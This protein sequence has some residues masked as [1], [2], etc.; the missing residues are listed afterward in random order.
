[1]LCLRGLQNKEKMA[2]PICVDCR[3]F[4][5]LFAIEGFFSCRILSRTS[6]LWMPV[7]ESVKALAVTMLRTQFPRFCKFNILAVS[8]WWY[9]FADLI[10]ALT[11]VK[12]Q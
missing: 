10:F 5:D 4:A 9:V 2:F 11:S 7:T 6:L 1:M 12:L 3:W 8:F